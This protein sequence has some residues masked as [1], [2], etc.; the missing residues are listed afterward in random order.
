MSY[1]SK[2]TAIRQLSDLNIANLHGMGGIVRERMMTFCLKN[3][4]VSV[5]KA[6]FIKQIRLGN[7]TSNPDNL[8]E[9]LFLDRVMGLQGEC[10]KIP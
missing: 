3:Y 2:E 10:C 1:K 5:Y 7:I 4:W 9:Y 6:A 8:I